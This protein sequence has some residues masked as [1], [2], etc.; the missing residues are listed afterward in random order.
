MVELTEHEPVA[1]YAGLAA[2]V[3][4]YRGR[5]LRLAVDDAGAGYASLRHVLAVRPDFV[6]V[7]MALTRGAD[8]D[9]A[10]RTLLT[11][12]A[13]FT[14]ALGGRLVAEGVETAAELAALRDCG[15]HLVQGYL[16]GRPAADPAWSR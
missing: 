16:L 1:D 7:D 10:R 15:V 8:S 9:V 13:S 2:A 5:G 12:L 6:K 4:P 14:T 11:A 3:Q